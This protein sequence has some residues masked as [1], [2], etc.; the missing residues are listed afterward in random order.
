MK[1]K[2]SVILDVLPIAISV[3]AVAISFC[4]VKTSVENNDAT[5][6][7]ELLRLQ[8]ERVVV[9]RQAAAAVVT[10]VKPIIY[11]GFSPEYWGENI[12]SWMGLFVEADTHLIYSVSINKPILAK[13]YAAWVVA[14]VEDRGP[15]EE[16]NEVIRAGRLD[17]ELLGSLVSSIRSIAVR[18]RSTFAAR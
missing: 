3:A 8:Y 6:E 17:E 11:D 7:V 13:Q 18:G 1:N 4:A 9:I 12:D 10:A 2:R 16:A 5:R 14:L 15:W